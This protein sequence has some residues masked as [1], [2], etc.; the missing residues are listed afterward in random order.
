MT[1]PQH[2]L[3]QQ[4]LDDIARQHIAGGVNVWPRLQARLSD[5]KTMTSRP[6]LRLIGTIALVLIALLAV[7]SVAYALYRVMTDP[8]LQAVNDAGLITDLN[9]SATRVPIELTATPSA[10]S[11]AP[12]A[13]RSASNARPAAT[14]TALA[15]QQLGDV[16]VTLNWAYADES[17]V[18]L[19]LTIRGLQ[20]PAGVKPHFLIN[21]ITLSDDQGTFFGRDGTSQSTA[22]RPDDPGV[23]EVTMINYQP[24]TAD[25]ALHLR[26]E[27]KLGDTTAPVI[28]SDAAPAS[29]PFLLVTI[30]PLANFHLQFEV[31]VYQALVVKP[32]QSIAANGSTIRLEEI[33]LSP[34]LIEA[35]LCYQLPDPSDWQLESHVHIGS[36]PAVPQSAIRLATGKASLNSNA[37]ERCVLVDYPASY[38]QH[39]GPLTLTV[40]S[41]HTSLPEVIPAEA[42]VRA[43]AGLAAQGIEFEYSVLDHGTR[44]TVTRKPADMSETE[45][46]QLAFQALEQAAERHVVGPWTFSIMTPEAVP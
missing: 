11:M 14:P 40:E 4:A 3:V 44:L 22:L 33:R 35:H 6:P 24:L 38:L 30:A 17:R 8:G 46:N 20:P 25:Q 15:A 7:A 18:A 12:S 37:D 23:V 5:Q 29:A 45:A 32:D 9:L 21:A 1:S 13:T 19:G 27:V 28:T 41:L 34:S 42:V 10:S 2:S 26:V 43:N 31:P 16:T 36:A 39:S